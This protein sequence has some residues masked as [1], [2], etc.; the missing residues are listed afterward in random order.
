MAERRRGLLRASR[1][2]RA[3]GAAASRAG[4]RLAAAGRRLAAAGRGL[5]SIGAR[6]LT[7]L[8]R[9]GGRRPRRGREAAQAP[10]PAGEADKSGE[11]RAR[12]EAEPAAQWRA[13]LSPLVRR[14]LAVNLIAL[15]F[16]AGGILY[17]T[18]FRANLIERRLDRLAVEAEIIAGALGESAT[19]GPEAS[20]VDSEEARRIIARLVGPTQ[21]RARLFSTEGALVVD[22]R[23]LPSSGQVMAET[24]PPLD[25]AP[26][27]SERA[28]GLVNAVLDAFAAEPELPVYR[29]RAEQRAQ[30]Y[31]EAVSALDGEPASRRRLLPDGTMLLSAAAPVQ[32]FRR[33]LG[34][35]MLSADTREIEAIVRA[36]QIT[37]LQVFAGA[38]A[39]TLIISLFLA[40][41]IARPI[42]RLAR[43]ADQVRRN[44][45][46]ET[47]LPQIERKDE[48]GGLSRALSEMTAALYRQIDAVESFAADVAHELK[49]PL[50]SLHS[51]V[52]SLERTDDPAMKARLVEIVQDDVRRIDRL[53]SDIS[54][55][56]RL[57]AELSRGR[58]ETVDLGELAN[59]LVRA[60]NARLAGESGEAPVRFEPPEPGTML[61]P[62]L[63]SRL[64]QV[65]TNL[66]DNAL[67]FSPEPGSVAL[68]LRRED[69]WVAVTVADSGPGLPEGAQDKIFE[70]FYSERPQEE[71]F[72][73]HSGLGLSICKQIV[74]AHGG[75]IRAENR[76]AGESED[77]EAPS[78]SPGAR[79]I[80][81]LPAA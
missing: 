42:N 37:I 28:A 67:S 76:D 64:G 79:F 34:A 35:L 19:G 52:E 18:E 78:A 14:I 74:A 56:S 10:G 22:S 66:L 11:T 65:I 31:V 24:L 17:L 41:T 70:R 55:A 33:V 59:S 32:R 60:Q 16:L 6:A 9:R 50:S 12:A 77:G 71:A 62:G 27:L 25:A 23:F 51:A 49:N 73:R 4:N 61:V 38:L 5:R 43:A 63:E 68:D 69:G 15:L 39:V 26:P 20:G 47:Q 40:S 30:D 53:I 36:E 3:L 81:R 46:R 2:G 13:G 57:D 8:I 44:I 21:T 7:R 58:M 75:E 80:L 1:G 72:G 48:I 54:D 29:E 45:G